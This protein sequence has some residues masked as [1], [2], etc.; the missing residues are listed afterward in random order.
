MREALLGNSGS[1]LVLVLVCMLCVSILGVMVMY[2][3]YT[4][5]MLKATE[6][7]SKTNFYDASTALDEIRAGIQKTASDSIAAA[8]KTMLV[9]YSYA[10]YTR[11]T[12]M[13]QKFKGEFSSNMLGSNLFYNGQYKT[14][15]LKD[16]V[17]GPA[18]VTGSG[19]VSSTVDGIILKGVTV[20]CTDTKGYTT[21]VTS[22]IS[23]GMPEF[24]YVVSNYSISGLPSL[25]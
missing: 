17:S 19:T 4:G 8:Y 9:N 23:V 21:T 10:D 3:S 20:S 14:D 16:F 25:H 22:D 11:N 15:A 12:T 24:S 2:L 18:Q 7:Q 1:G 5:L 6:R 13:E